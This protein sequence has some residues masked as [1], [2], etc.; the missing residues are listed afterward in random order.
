MNIN[1]DFCLEH[2][3]T[4]EEYYILFNL[5]KPS[6]KFIEYCE[7]FHY[8]VTFKT[9]I[10]KLQ[11][12]EFVKTILSDVTS[13]I[14][15]T[16]VTDTFL[17]LTQITKENAWKEVLDVY[18]VYGYINN[19]KVNLLN[20]RDEKAKNYYYNVIIQNGKLDLHKK[21]IEI[22]QFHFQNQLERGTRIATIS[23]DYNCLGLEKFVFSWD[24]FIRTFVKENT[25]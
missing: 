16:K 6:D 22:V 7:K 4:V 5:E 20:F 21:F 13:T 1:L 25:K 23:S 9:I 24:A 8:S 18:P 15:N 12:L 17:N 2:N 14:K 3:L 10:L 19:K 11:K